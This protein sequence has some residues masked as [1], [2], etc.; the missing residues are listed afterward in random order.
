MRREG[1]ANSEDSNSRRMCPPPGPGAGWPGGSVPNCRAAG[2]PE[3]AR[4]KQT[5]HADFNAFGMDA[6]Y[7]W[8]EE[9]A[10]E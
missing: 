5:G 6:G 3:V 9:V 8:R 10:V 2:R 7:W 1:H 4:H